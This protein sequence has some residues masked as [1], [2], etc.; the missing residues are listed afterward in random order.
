MLP[1]LLDSGL[2]G[3]ILDAI[4]SKAEYLL[5]ESQ[6]VPR[7]HNP[8]LVDLD[9][10][11]LA[12]LQPFTHLGRPVAGHHGQLLLQALQLL[13]QLSVLI[14]GLLKLLGQAR[15]ALQV[16]RVTC[17]FRLRT[18]EFCELLEECCVL[19]SLSLLLIELGFTTNYLLKE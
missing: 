11:E 18:I 19:T 2:L 16:F 17:R 13:L 9:G 7:E 15:D 12:V 8:L 5:G 4:F 3:H 1:E 14:L 10:G 6:E